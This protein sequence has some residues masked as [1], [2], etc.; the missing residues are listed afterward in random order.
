[1]Q[2]FSTFFYI[3]SKICEKQGQAKGSCCISRIYYVPLRPL[4]AQKNTKTG[5]ETITLIYIIK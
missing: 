4:V 5:K 3:F 1:M 2:I